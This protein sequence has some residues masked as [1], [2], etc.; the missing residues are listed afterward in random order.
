M[1][2][3]QLE[4]INFGK[5]SN[6]TFTLS[7]QTHLFYGLNEAGKTTLHAFIEG[8]FYG[9]L[10]PLSKRK[11]WEADYDRYKPK[12]GK[13]YKGNLVFKKDDKLYRLERNFL[14]RQDSVKLYLEQT[15]EDITHTLDIDPVTKQADIAKFIDM[16]Y[17][18]YKNTLSI[19]QLN[20]ATT[21]D[22]S[23]DLLR[24]L[25]NLEATKT[26]SFSAS[27]AIELLSKELADIGTANA[28]TKPYAKTVEGL[29]K[30]ETEYREAKTKH[31]TL[32]S[33]KEEANA[34]K[35]TLDE[36]KEKLHSVSLKVKAQQNTIKIDNHAQLMQYFK[37]FKETLNSSG[38][39]LPDDFLNQAPALKKTHEETLKQ[40]PNL[41]KA[42][43]ENHTKKTS[44]EAQLLKDY[45]YVSE[46]D[47]TKLTKDYH[48]ALKLESA[49]DSASLNRLNHD[50]EQLMTRLKIEEDALESINQTIQ[51]LK[52]KTTLK[53]WKVFLIIPLF[54]RL[55]RFNLR[56][57]R[58]KHE[59]ERDHYSANIKRLKEDEATLL[60]QM[61]RVKKQNDM[62]IHSV[63][64]ILTRYNQRSLEDLKL[65][66]ETTKKHYEVSTEQARFQKAYDDVNQ[67]L[68]KIKQ[69]TKVL[70]ETFDLDFT[71]LAFDACMAF[72]RFTERLDHITNQKPYRTFYETIDFEADPVSLDGY[73]DNKA[74]LKSLQE[75]IHQQ[76][77]AYQAK[78]YQVKSLMDS[79]R[80]LAEIDSEIEALRAKIHAYDERKTLLSQSISH[81]EAAVKEIEEN[82]AP[83]LSETIGEFLK[84][85]TL[86]TYDTIKVR[87]DL[88]FKVQSTLNTLEDAPYF[89]SGT[90][91]QIYFA[92]RLGILKILNKDHLPIILDD[93]FVNFDDDRLKQAL[94]TLTHFKEDSQLILFTC[95]LREEKILNALNSPFH[96]EIITSVD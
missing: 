2:I 22:A 33:L 39:T 66:Y 91:D 78:N 14:K 74:Q 3:K 27:K 85:F 55:L 25:Q 54:I 16:P 32:L 58:F 45:Q 56:K 12:N 94:K 82:F 67:A 81:L 41:S 60:K 70:F 5:F 69:E 79:T 38:G 9:F 63:N 59:I 73:E 29:E 49:I 30:A 93:A 17:T 15:G 64:Q 10:S 13:D 35:I 52:N 21:S 36:T 57:Q 77:K 37:G 11:I 44:I 87:K 65:Y 7:D 53:T 24:R 43:T 95:H 23:D 71:S 76:E 46:T 62:A 80:D 48:N 68:S 75:T 4:L 20:Q 50:Y 90:K 40:L 83:L 18:L 26:E 61:Q 84:A 89:S 28:H 6:K 34:I 51:T 88:T 86:D 96:K 19:K 92:M 31:E 47:M 8:M 1:I 42:Y 72:E